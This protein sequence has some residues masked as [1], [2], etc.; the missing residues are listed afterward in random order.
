MFQEGRRI[1]LRAIPR[2]GNGGSCFAVRTSI[3]MMKT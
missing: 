3:N 2:K 1:V